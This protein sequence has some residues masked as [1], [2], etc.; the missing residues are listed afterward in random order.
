MKN[1]IRLSSVLFVALFVLGCNKS[2]KIETEKNVHTHKN[3]KH[4]CNH[5]SDVVFHNFPKLHFTVSPLGN[6][7]QSDIDDAVKI[8]KEFY[9]FDCTIG[10]YT[11]ITNDMYLDGTSVVNADICIGKLFSQKKVVYIIENRLWS[12]GDYLRGYA[13]RNGGT[14]LVRGDKSFLRETL[15]HE[16]GHTLGLPHC[17]DLT[18]IM[19]VENDEYDK[20]TFCNKCFNKLG[21]TPTNTIITK[22]SDNNSFIDFAEN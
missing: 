7:D 9:G 17:D 16:I 8:I 12:T 1:L 18:C 2:N 3:C 14:V 21:V 22:P 6:V 13:A 5:S 10:T 4:S 15:I 20:G 19:G 11:P